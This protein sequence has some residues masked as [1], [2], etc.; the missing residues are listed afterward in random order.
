VDSQ[1]LRGGHRTRDRHSVRISQVCL[2]FTRNTVEVMIF[3]C[4]LNC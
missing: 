2:V 4:S 3:T 1:P